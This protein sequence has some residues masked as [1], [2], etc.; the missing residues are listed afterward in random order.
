MEGRTSIHPPPGSPGRVHKSLDSALSRV[1]ESVVLVCTS[2]DPQ[3]RR[4][5]VRCRVHQCWA[6]SRYPVDSLDLE[7]TGHGVELVTFLLRK[8]IVVGSYKS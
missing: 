8:G 6:A 3:G 2:S 1:G 4:G 7:K 5:Q